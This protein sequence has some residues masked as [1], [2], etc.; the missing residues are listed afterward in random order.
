MKK[1]LLIPVLM[2]ISILIVLPVL[3]SGYTYTISVTSAAALSDEPVLVS[4][5][6]TQLVTSGYL[7]PTG[8]D[9]TVYDGTTA[10]PTMVTNNAVGFVD[11]L[12][13]STKTVQY[14]TGIT[15]GA[16]SMPLIVGHGGYLTT[17][18]TAAL[19]MGTDWE[20]DISASVNL[21]DVGAYILNKAGE[22]TIKVT[23]DNSI[24]ATV[25]D[26]AAKT[27]VLTDLSSINFL[28]LSLSGGVLTFTVNG[29]TGTAS[30]GTV[31]NNTNA[32]IWDSD[33]LVMP[34][35]MSISQ[36]R[37][38]PP[39]SFSL[40]QPDN[41]TF[42]LLGG[43][44]PVT[45]SPFPFVALGQYFDLGRVYSSVSISSIS[46]DLWKWIGS[47]IG[48]AT[49]KVYPEESGD[50]SNNY[51]I[52]NDYGSSEAQTLGTID[53]SSLTTSSASYTFNYHTCTFSNISGFVVD[54]EYNNG[55]DANKIAV[56]E[57]DY[58]YPTINPN[59][60]RMIVNTSISPGFKGNDSRSPTYVMSATFSN[61][62][63]IVYYK[64]NTIISGTVLPDLDGTANGVITW[65]TNYT[66]VTIATGSFQ[67]S[68]PASYIVSQ[69]QYQQQSP[70]D[71]DLGNPIAPPQ[72]YTGLDTSKFPGGA[73]IDA[74]LDA[75]EVPH[76]LWWYPFIFLFVVIVSMMGYDATQSTGGQG[77]LLTQ[78]II[79]EVLLVIFG[80][81]GDTGVAS[82]IPLWP[83]ILFPLPAIAMIMSRRHVGWG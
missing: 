68:K 28:V 47:P 75:G 74:L 48:T 25:Y 7:T 29:A 4:V 63:A 66:G 53:V 72:L 50:I 36:Q 65:G 77:S 2:V 20:L 81:L 5:N 43:D 9:A 82:L 38:S 76:A 18:Y 60:V 57:T 26:G 83:A 80:V 31:V 51:G 45:G 78:C 42:E 27:I 44:N 33:G 19:E 56:G 3:A 79:A 22:A 61:L 62:A 54:I 12:T 35:I 34:Y 58:T 17:P 39:P 71:I 59:G 64:P 40:T 13:A 15:P 49:V 37:P 46:L 67:P 21:S 73:V 8:L 55:N 41:T 32:W 6:N 1:L 11:D 69:S 30:V 52:I 10:L 24:T 16:T 23:A 70:G 14:I